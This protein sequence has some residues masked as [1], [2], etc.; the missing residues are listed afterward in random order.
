MIHG[1]LVSQPTKRPFA[2]DNPNYPQLVSDQP[3]TNFAILNYE[4]TGKVS[5]VWRVIQMN[6]TAE[7]E[8]LKGLKF[9]GMLGYY[10]AYN[11]LDNQEFTYELYGYDEQK[12]NY[13][14]T[15][16]MSNPYRE[17][18]REKVEDQFSNFQLNFDRKFGKHAVVAVAGFEASQRKRPKMWIHSTPVSNAMDLIRLKEIQEFNDDGNRTEARMGYLGRINYSYADKYLV[19]LIARWDGSWKFR[20]DNRWGFFPSASLGWRVSEENF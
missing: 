6:G 18:N 19:E 16:R 7:Y 20:P 10:Y 4:T 8:I 13:Y 3:E 11:E 12:D 14:V 15:N 9:K 17:R 2:N 5:D 1:C